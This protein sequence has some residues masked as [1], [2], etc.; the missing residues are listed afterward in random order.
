MKD[1][2]NETKS[3][4]ILATSLV[5]SNIENQKKAVESWVKL[6][7]RVISLNCKEEKEN[8]I[9]HFPNVEFI[10]VKRDGRNEYGKPYVYFDDFMEYFQK[11]TA[12]ICGIINSDIHLLGV[13]K[14]FNNFIFKEAYDSLVFGSRVDVDTLDN[15]KGIMYN[16]YDYFFF[17]KKLSFIYPKE[18]FCIGQP[19]WDIWIVFMPLLKDIKVKKII[20]PIAYHIK[21]RLNWNDET[22]IRLFQKILNK[23]LGH[24]LE[25]NSKLFNDIN[26]KK[27]RRNIDNSPEAIFYKNHNNNQR[28]LV[29][30]DDCNAIRE[31]SVTYSS[32]TN[33]SYKNIRIINAKRDKFDINYV[34]EELIYF[35]SEGVVLDKNFFK[36]IVNDIKDYDCTISGITL[37]DDYESIFQDIYLIEGTSIISNMVQLIKACI[38]FK[39]DFLKKCSFDINNLSKY[40]IG[41]IGKALVRVD[42]YE[43]VKSRINK[44]KPKNLFIY[45]AGEHT[46]KLL[47]YIDFSEFNLEGII[48]KNES[49]EGIKVNQYQVFHPT[50]I[51]E[52]KFDYILI[53]S[54]AFEK[55][56]YDELSKKINKEKIIRL[57]FN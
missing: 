5:P 6:G 55:E 10:E 43:Y 1:K 45:G 35:I 53:S 38:I 15:L 36:I 18:N 30:Y 37:Q 49:L 12:Q 51:Q 3:Q 27:F 16:G 8:L 19:V 22:C 2:I 33:Q 34:D 44:F 24:K 40:N 29:V 26:F 46:K 13:D 23:Y 17:D 56:I 39:T 57:Y 47:N 32:I 41:F 50:K 7:F 20:D 52:L 28:I 25:C 11:C 31:T 9:E 14:E 54:K 21:H 42:Y 4:I 48:D